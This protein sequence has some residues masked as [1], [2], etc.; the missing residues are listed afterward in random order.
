MVYKGWLYLAF[1]FERILLE[2]EFWVHSYFLPSCESFS[3]MGSWGLADSLTITSWELICLFSL[4]IFNIV[5]LFLAF[6]SVILIQPSVDFFLVILLVILIFKNNG[7]SLSSV[8]K[9][10]VIILPNI[11][12]AQFSLSLPFR[13]QST[14][15]LDH[16]TLFSMSLTSLFYYFDF[17]CSILCNS[18]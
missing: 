7:W 10:P 13:A 11:S 2:L 8:L 4:A 9:I 18:F 5:Y 17:L 3:F 15:G 12:S 16:L 6:W 1:V 14:L